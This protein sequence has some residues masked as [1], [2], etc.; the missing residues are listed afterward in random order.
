M[1]VGDG[2]IVMGMWVSVCGWAEGCIGDIYS[3]SGSR[4]WWSGRRCRK[5]PHISGGGVAGRTGSG[6]RRAA[7]VSWAARG[8]GE[9]VV[10]RGVVVSRVEERA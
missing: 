7:E 8:Q 2:G 4:C 1:Y 5:W 9:F 6:V 3:R 10:D